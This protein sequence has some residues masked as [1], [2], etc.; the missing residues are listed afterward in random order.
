MTEKVYVGSE[1]HKR[2]LHQTRDVPLDK[3]TVTGCPLDLAVFEDGQK[4]P[5]TRKF[6]YVGRKTDE[7]GYDI[8]Q[9]LRRDGVPITASMEE[10][11]DKKR[12]YHEL[13]ASE[14]IVNPARQETFGIGMM[15][16][17]ASNVPV[18]VP[19]TP[20][21]QT[22]VPDK[23]RVDSHDFLSKPWFLDSAARVAEQ[24]G[25]EREIVSQYDYHNVMEKWFT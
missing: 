17:F 7:K 16:A 18:I 12:F 3:V 23:Y 1:Y 8:V 21:F 13:A 19:N 24:A 11:W 15:E 20:Q 9:N 22:T 6:L 25:N 2:L 4:T 10:G 5:K 14:M